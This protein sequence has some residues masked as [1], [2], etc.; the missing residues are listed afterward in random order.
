MSSADE[1]AVRLVIIVTL[2]VCTIGY[3]S[4]S[5]KGREKQYPKTWDAARAAYEAEIGELQEKVQTAKKNYDNESRALQR[6]Q[7]AEINSLQKK[8]SAEIGTLQK[9]Q[10]AEVTSFE[11]SSASEVGELKEKNKEDLIRTRDD[12]Y[13]AGQIEGRDAV[14]REIDSKARQNMEKGDWN[15][16]VYS[17]RK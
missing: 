4:G 12:S 11:Q 14:Q 7:N 15:A 17:I 2:A 8:Q 5:S 10:S 9:K 13:L 3:C 1:G 16:P 6:R